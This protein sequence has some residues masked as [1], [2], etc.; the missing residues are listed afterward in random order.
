M[1]DAAGDKCVVKLNSKLLQLNLNG[2]KV[3][4]TFENGVS[5]SFCHAS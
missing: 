3:E 1:V 2:K 5:S 4:T